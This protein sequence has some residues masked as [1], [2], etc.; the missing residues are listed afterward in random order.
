MVRSVTPSG[1]HVVIRHDD[2]PGFMDAM[3]MAF[4]VATPSVVAGVQRDDRIRFRFVAG[5]QGVV[6][7]HV[8]PASAE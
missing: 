7:Q 3:T 4:A 5:T 8:E 6:V 1:S 2:I